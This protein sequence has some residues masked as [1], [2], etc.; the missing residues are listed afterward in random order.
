MIEEK[1]SDKKRFRRRLK[2][3]VVSDVND[4]T[5]V[6]NVSRR[7]KHPMYNKFIAQTK[8]YHVHDETNSAKIGDQVSIVESRPF[9]AKKRWELLK[10]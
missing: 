9:S 7:F 5:V 6:V 10:K 4:K 3:V 8:K 1:K 2:G